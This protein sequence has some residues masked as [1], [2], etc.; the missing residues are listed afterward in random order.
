MCS[1]PLIV[2]STNHF[3]LKCNYWGITFAVGEIIEQEKNDFWVFA[4]ERTI[5]DH[6]TKKTEDEF[7]AEN[8]GGLNARAWLCLDLKAELF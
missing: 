3:I 2:V 1:N 8:I 4:N 6:L 7:S 5:S